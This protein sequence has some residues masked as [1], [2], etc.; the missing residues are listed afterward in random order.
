LKYYERNVMKIERILP[1]LT[2]ASLILLVPALCAASVVYTYTGLP[3]TN[4]QGPQGVNFGA[5]P[6]AGNPY[7]TLDLVSGT[8]TLSSPLLYNDP[9]LTN[10]YSEVTAEDFTDGY[11]TLDT[12][13]AAGGNEE[14]YFATANGVITAWAV[15][16][17]NPTETDGIGTAWGSGND[18]DYGEEC[19]S[20]CSGDNYSEIGYNATTPGI[21]EGVLAGQ[22]STV[23][24]P[25]PISTLL[26][27][28]ILLAGK[29]Q[30]QRKRQNP[31]TKPAARERSQ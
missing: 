30:F 22:G 17:Y 6:R 18:I 8:V 23:P 13:T 21:W 5:L 24:E 4:G 3:F 20:Q 12:L 15:E 31:R 7:T 25:S 19:P 11:G 27:A 2:L 14:F 28:S 1:F 10:Y 16:V 29:V 26:P 9:T